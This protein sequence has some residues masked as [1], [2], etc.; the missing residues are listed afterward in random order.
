MNF[1]PTWI[2]VVLSIIIGI[3]AGGFNMYRI[4]YIRGVGDPG[5]LTLPFSFL[6]W[7]VPIIIII[8]IIYSFIQ[9]KKYS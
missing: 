3:I 9:K 2:K 1:K 6:I 4:D 7:F 5:P 8:Y